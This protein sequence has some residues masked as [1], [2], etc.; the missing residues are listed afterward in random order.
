MAAGD[1]DIVDCAAAVHLLDL[2]RS[3]PS[4][5]LHPASSHLKKIKNTNSR[6]TC[7]ES[8]IVGLG[9]DFQS[10]EVETHSSGSIISTN[11]IRT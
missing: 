1:D 6:S 10:P 7:W 2:S 4:S 3:L 11:E 9:F 8:R 5:V